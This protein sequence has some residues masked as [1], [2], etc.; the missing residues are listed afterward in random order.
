VQIAMAKIIYKVEQIAPVHITVIKMPIKLTTVIV[1]AL[2]LVSFAHAL[3]G[4]ILT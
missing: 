3:V 1:L 2:V 4:N